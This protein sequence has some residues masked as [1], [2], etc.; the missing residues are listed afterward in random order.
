MFY[1]ASMQGAVPE[2]WWECPALDSVVALALGSDKLVMTPKTSLSATEQIPKVITLFIFVYV[3]DCAHVSD[4]PWGQV[5]VWQEIVPGEVLK[6]GPPWFLRCIFHWP[7]ACQVNSADWPA[8]LREGSSCLSLPSPGIANRTRVIPIY[9]AFSQGGWG[10]D[11]GCVSMSL[12]NKHFTNWAFSS[13]PYYSISR[14]SLSHVKS[15]SLTDWSV[16]G[17]FNPLDLHSFIV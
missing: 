8:R 3:C 1:E 5:F 12:H 13:A 4:C 7:G 11:S 15:F 9:L 2:W 6:W 14:M 17:H 16:H 10:W